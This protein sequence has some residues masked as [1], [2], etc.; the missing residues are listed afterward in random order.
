MRKAKVLE[1]GQPPT[2]VDEILRRVEFQTFQIPILGE[3]D[4]GEIIRWQRSAHPWTLMMDW[5]CARRDLKIYE[6]TLREVGPVYN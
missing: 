4:R 1:M 3:P 2:L 5:A 6:K